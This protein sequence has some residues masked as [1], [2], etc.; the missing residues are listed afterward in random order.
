MSLSTQERWLHLTFEGIFSLLLL[1]GLLANQFLL[2]AVALGPQASHPLLVSTASLMANVT[3]SYW[4]FL[5]FEAPSRP[6]SFSNQ[7]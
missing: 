1:L 2:L 7:S 6:P 4:H 5:S 3:L